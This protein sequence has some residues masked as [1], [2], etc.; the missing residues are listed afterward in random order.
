MAPRTNPHREDPN[1]H[2]FIASLY[3]THGTFDEGAKASVQI[4]SSHQILAKVRRQ[5]GNSDEGT[6]T[7][8][9]ARAQAH[10]MAA[11]FIRQARRAANLT[12]QQLAHRLDV[13][14]SYLSDAQSF[15]SVRKVPL[16]FLLRVALA[17]GGD[18]SL[19]FAQK[20]GKANTP[21]PT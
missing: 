11:L 12:T 4:P 21:S 3:K 18:L 16:D 20:S 15:K 19:T 17:C 6:L 2:E 7:D 1:F 8:A 10:Q 5:F 13:D 9:V 14:L